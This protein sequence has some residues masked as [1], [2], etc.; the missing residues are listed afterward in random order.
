MTKRLA[1]AVTGELGSDLALLINRHDAENGEPAFGVTVITP[2][3]PPV[4]QR[5]DLIVFLPPS[6][7]HWGGNIAERWAKEHL[8]A[9]LAPGGRLEFA[10]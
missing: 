8:P 3:S 9:L 10:G 5:F 1:L 7:L 2:A 4:N 6:K